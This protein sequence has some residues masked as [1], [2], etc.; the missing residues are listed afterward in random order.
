MAIQYPHPL[1]LPFKLSPEEPMT[2][3]H[4]TL[5]GQFQLT[6]QDGVAAH[7]ATEKSRALLAF[8]T[9]TPAQIHTRDSLATLLWPEYGDE[10]AR[11]NLRQTLYRLKQTLERVHPLLWEKMVQSSRTT[12]CFQ[13]DGW[14][15]VDGLQVLRE[16]DAVARH[17]HSHLHTCSE[18][19]FRLD[20]AVSLYG[21]DLLAG[22]RM[23]ESAPYEEWAVRERERLHRLIV[24]A[25]TDLAEAY[26]HRGEPEKAA[27]YARRHLEFEPWAER[28]HRQLIRAYLNRGQ[29][30]D[31]LLQYERCRVVLAQELGME[32]DDE[33]RSLYAEVSAPLAPSPLSQPAQQPGPAVLHNFPMQLTPFV[34]RDLEIQSILDQLLDPT[35]RLLTLIGSGGA[36]KTRLAVETG[37]LLASRNQLAKQ[38]CPDGIYFINLADLA[39]HEW[40]LTALAAA[41][42]LT[43]TGPQSLQQQV[44]RFLQDRRLLLLLDNAEH[45]IAGDSAS[46]VIQLITLIL[47]QAAGVKL[48]VTSREPLNLRA[49]QRIQLDGL[50]YPGSD[51]GDQDPAHFG[52]V[53]LFIRAA[54]QIQPAFSP[55]QAELATVGRIC[56]LVRG[57]PLALEIA[58]AW[59]RLMDCAAIEREIRRSLDFLASPALDAPERHRSL[60]AV[61]EYSY[62]LLQPAEQTAFA[63]LTL[64]VDGFSLEAAHSICEVTPMLLASLADKCL[65]Q[66]RSE[67]RYQ[68]HELVEQFGAEKLADQQELA[69]FAQ[70]HSHFYLRLLQAPDQPDT[71]LLSPFLRDEI[72][73]EIGNVRQAWSV[74]VQN[75]DWSLLNATCGWLSQY[76][77]LR[78]FYQEAVDLFAR[79]A[80]EIQAAPSSG[81]SRQDALSLLGRLGLYQGRQLQNLGRFAQALTVLQEATIH[82]IS[83]QDPDVYSWILAELGIVHWRL[84]RLEQGRQV[85][86]QSLD[87]A[88]QT[89]NPWRTA[90]ALHHL[91]NID[92]ISQQM[93]SALTLLRQAFRIY[94]DLG[95]PWWQA[96]VLNDIAACLTHFNGAEQALDALRESQRLFLEASDPAQALLPL[97]N[98]G[99]CLMVVG[100]Y[101]EAEAYLL[102][103]L[104]S[105]RQL[106]LLSMQIGLLANLGQLYAIQQQFQSARIYYLQALRLSRGS[107]ELVQ[108]AE[109]LLGVAYLLAQA[110]AWVQAATILAELE[111]RSA[112]TLFTDEVEGRLFRET[113][114]LLR[115]GELPPLE[116]L[117][118][119]QFSLT[120]LSQ[121][122]ADWLAR[123]ENLFG[124]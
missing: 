15:T 110:G 55:T 61:F 4:L 23:E 106:K 79:T 109:L 17:A 75:E 63:R 111:E 89:G 10:D 32:P 2:H 7:F 121:Q 49:E 116:H 95:Q 60:R 78:G 114:Q 93:A 69:I 100:R 59:L 98:L 30:S 51:S 16:I 97:T 53:Q 5:L 88:R 65:V 84:G 58:S 64:F 8:L 108:S 104:H 115:E 103:G 44:L 86:E 43:L 48:L 18:C 3:A 81:A 26:L 50:T 62:Q 112:L 46:T 91:G 33:T 107:D 83:D 54:R 13:P 24:E 39:S 14:I 101:D 1:M 70:A 71:T 120:N 90:Y 57:I 40:V 123:I 113:R 118:T 21:G 102:K 80:Q 28:A 47:N 20:R 27:A 66:R 11:R 117:P 68:L 56:R 92:V 76:F 73:L 6:S 52:A 85:L 36:G 82:G 77:Q 74:A 105:A 22:I 94:Q 42:Q 41:L 124:Q 122:A 31:A 96:G 9:L 25:L 34:G 87:L 38:L 67:G 29:R 72:D 35:N 99:Y 45:L 119:V 19:L 37:R 12:I